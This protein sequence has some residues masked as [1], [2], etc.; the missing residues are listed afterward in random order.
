MS[1]VVALNS[2]TSLTPPSVSTQMP[3]APVRVINGTTL[4]LLGMEL[5]GLFKQYA[6]DRQLTE[7]KF[8]RNLRQ[9]LGIYDPEVEKDLPVNGSRAYPRITRVKCISM[10]ARVMNLM[11]PGN[12]RSWEL[13]A[14]PSAEM[15]PGDVKVAVQELRA[16]YEADGIAPPQLSFEFVET[17]IQHLADKRAAAISKLID[18]QLQEIG[19]DQTHD[20]ISLNR[21]VVFSGIKYGLGLLEGPYVKTE[22]K[23]LW[24]ADGE[25]GFKPSEREIRKP[26]YEFVSVWDFYP[27]M[28]AKTLGSGDGYFIR[29]V[30]GR[31]DFR[32]LA[33]RPDFMADQVKKYLNQFP[34][35]NYVAKPFELD[36]KT[37]GTKA[38][39]NELRTDPHGKYEV[40][41]WKGLV[42]AHK[43]ME[44]GV[45]V[46]EK[47]Q[48]DDV[49][50]EIWLVDHYVIKA[51]I[52]AW[53]KMGCE[54]KTI[55]PFVF[56][57][58]DTSPI[59]NGLPNV[60]RDSQMSVC[61]SVR[62]ALDNA[63]VTCGPNL[64][65]NTALL[66]NG[67]DISSVH[68]YKVWER[69]DDGLTSQYPAVREIKFDAHL[70]ELKALVEMF[71]TFADM[72]TFIG[73]A[74]GG[75][76]DKMPSEPARTAAGQSMMKGDAALPFKDIIRNF[77][78]F[79]QSVILSLVHFNRKFNPHLAKEGDYDVI[80]RGA[81]SLIAK[82]VRG[83]QTDILA[84]TLT[85]EDRD[86][87]DEEKFIKQRMAVRDMEGLM[88]SSEEALR[89]RAA[90]QA[91]IAEMAD[92]EKQ[93]MLAEIRKTLSE[94]VKN[95]AQAAKNQAGADATTTTTALDIMEMGMNDGEPE[96]TSSASRK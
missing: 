65:V 41:I 69:D 71:M 92:L 1:Q 39:V 36:L 22:K 30:L 16:K 79:T 33:D 53:R 78:F 49:E 46:P 88:V 51:D 73:P 17:A 37:M 64:E 31:A 21:Q 7:Q 87:I 75:D 55:H 12:E 56:D 50:A 54:V 29:K 68:A 72:E 44:I 25:G 61:A 95:V 32:K 63:S 66:V 48:A 80:A 34:K 96:G 93:T 42:T 23:V 3:D 83:M 74:T 26:L 86:W 60:V 76:I 67:Q 8:I 82:E 59:G 6:D 13:G 89:K 58:D 5:Q 2:T 38:N 90:R 24:G 85:P 77:D 19:G 4:T 10:L 81:T 70:P 18:D 43:L 47:Y 35:G 28:S 27:D 14:S 15:H 94:A 9:Y 91:S 84:Q 45:D 57:E 20:Y 52:N 40:I 11:F 62:M